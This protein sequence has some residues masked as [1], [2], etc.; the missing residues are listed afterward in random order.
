MG[1]TYN[2]IDADGHVLEPVDIWD[3]YMDPAYRDRAPR[4]IVDKDG[5]ERLSVA[6]AREVRWY[7]VDE[8]TFEP[9]NFTDSIQVRLE[10]AYAN[11]GAWGYNSSMGGGYGGQIQFTTPQTASS[12]EQRGESLIDLIVTIVEPAAWARNGGR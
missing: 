4:I 2:V 10:Q 9:P 12:S 3:K 11:S 7:P 5:K 6:S 8:V 1:R